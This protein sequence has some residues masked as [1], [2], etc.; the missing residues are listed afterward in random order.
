VSAVSCNNLYDMRESLTSSLSHAMGGHHC[1]HAHHP[2]VTATTRHVGYDSN[3]LPVHTA[4]WRPLRQPCNGRFNL[5]S[6][7]VFVVLKHTNTP[8]IVQSKTAA[9]DP[10]AKYSL[11]G[12]R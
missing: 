6:S 12:L 2:R 8:K 7:F 4:P 10:T 9:A 11:H 3:S 1:G 5:R